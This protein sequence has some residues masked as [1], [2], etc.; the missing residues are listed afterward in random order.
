MGATCAVRPSQ[1]VVLH[2]L[3]YDDYGLQ[4]LYFLRGAKD[5]ITRLVQ[6][7]MGPEMDPCDQ[8]R[9]CGLVMEHRGQHL[10]T[11]P[12][13]RSQFLWMQWQMPLPPVMEPIRP[14]PLAPGLWPPPHG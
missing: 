4:E 2:R 7:A 3:L 9:R 13:D 12:G 10:G 1:I 6:T 14:D 5:L 8:R 11:E